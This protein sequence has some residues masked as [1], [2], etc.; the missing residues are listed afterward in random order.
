MKILEICPYSSGGCGVWAR[1]KQESVELAKKGYTVKIFSSNFEK[2][3]NKIVPLKEMLPSVEI[4]RFP[5]KKIGG[6]SFMKFNFLKEAVNYSPDIIFVHSYRHLH[7]TQALKLRN[8]LKKRRENCKIFLVTHAPFV[9]GNLTRTKFQ[10][11][12]V[13]LYDKFIGPKIINKFDKILSISKWEIPF[14]L[15]CGAKKEK[16]VLVPNGIPQ[17]FFYK[18]KTVKEENKILFL[19]RIS[20]IKNLEVLIKSIPLLKDKKIKLELVGPK[21]E[22]YFIYLNNIIAELKIKERILFI[23]PIYNLN[24]KI[25]KIDSAKIFILPSKK[26][27]MPQSLIEAMSRRKIVIGSDIPAIRELIHDKENGLLFKSDNSKDLADKINFALD[28]KNSIMIKNLQIN[29]LND[30]KK[31]SENRLISK[32][33]SFF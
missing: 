22:A 6:E 31:Y 12:V 19:G 25:K 18:E 33:E 17:E 28:T 26:E 4:Y 2:G 32:L 23:N 7:T 5:S 11:L 9:S 21:E 30:S 16:I 13:E 27:G 20:S 10:A 8:S 29:A 15:A 1:V 24:E 3:T 14:L